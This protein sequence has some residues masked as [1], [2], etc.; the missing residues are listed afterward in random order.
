VAAAQA[1]LQ[2]PRYFLKPSP[3]NVFEALF[4]NSGGSDFGSL[5][6]HYVKSSY[7]EHE[8]AIVDSELQGIL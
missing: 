5:P 6:D 7:A 3:P 4:G 1:K 8:N 2:Q